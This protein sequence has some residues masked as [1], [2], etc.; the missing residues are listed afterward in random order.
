[1]LTPDLARDRAADIVQRAIAAGAD[2]ADAVFAA[3][4]S[5]ELVL[6]GR[7]ERKVSVMGEVTVQAPI[8]M[9]NGNLSLNEALNEAGGVNLNLANPRQIYVIRNE[10]TGGQ[11][12]FHLDART[13]TALALADGFALRA[14]DVVYVD[15]VPL[16][17]WNR[18]I[19][20]ILPS[21]A[22]LNSVRD[23][24]RTNR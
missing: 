24:S 10:P 9:R 15:P 6:C 7:D 13:P 14:R 11:A 22:T 3:D 21:T 2:A 5:L 20:L 12:I 8:L 4:A 16:V 18:V 23:I 1:M 17:Q 19:S